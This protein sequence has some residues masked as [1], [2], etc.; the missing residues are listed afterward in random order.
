MCESEKGWWHD[1]NQLTKYTQSATWQVG[2]V[3]ALSKII[4]A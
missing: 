2:T 4:Q 1:T 3:H